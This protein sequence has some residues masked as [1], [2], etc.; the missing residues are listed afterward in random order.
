MMLNAL[1]LGAVAMASSIA[2]LFF[3]RYWRKTGDFLF[4]LFALAF[5]VDAFTRIVLGL[6]LVGNETE[7]AIY[8]GRL[9]TFLLIILGI[10]FKNRK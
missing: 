2:S 7:P 5:I 6:N 1:L 10:A 9:I 4:L 8:L 3:V